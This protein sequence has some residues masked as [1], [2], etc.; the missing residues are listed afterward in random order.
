MK[1]IETLWKG[2]RFRSRAE[3]RWAVFLDRLG[4]EFDYEPEGVILP[5]GPYLPDFRLKSFPI[6]IFPDGRAEEAVWL[7]VK[8]SEPTETERLRCAELSAEADA[9]VILAWGAP[10]FEPQ[11]L[12]FDRGQDPTINSVLAMMIGYLTFVDVGDGKEASISV[13][14]PARPVEGEEFRDGLGEACSFA[15]A[16]A[17]EVLWREFSGPF[18]RV[19]GVEGARF[20]SND[21]INFRLS[22]RI[23]A[24]YD[25]ARS[26]RFE[27]GQT[28]K[29]W[30]T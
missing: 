26:A 5:S 29:R 2:F 27:F 13:G 6:G 20:V 18:A 24:A 7:E 19:L 21:Q 9:P 10:N 22:D 8:G 4:I 11:I 14:R 3:A 16:E 17:F 15:E 28:D 12:L 23:K 25:A 1:A 30:P